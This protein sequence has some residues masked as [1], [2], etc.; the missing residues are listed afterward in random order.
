MAALAD[1]AESQKIFDKL[2]SKPANKVCFDCG[3]KAPTWASVPFGIYLCL[4]CSAVHRNL[5]VHI[6]FVRSTVLDQW[7]WDQLR[8]M[9]VG[10]NKAIQEFF[11]D[12][13]GSAALSAKD[14]KVKYQSNAATKYKEEIKRRAA[15]DA[16]IHPEFDVDDGAIVV[17]AEEEEEDFFSSWDKPAIKR[18][19]PS[20][21]RTGTPVSRTASPFLNANAAGNGTSRPKSPLASGAKA[22]TPAGTPPA[23]VVSKAVPAA[24]AAATRAKPTGAGA[25][26]AKR[27]VLSG[28]K[29]Q[30]IGAKKVVAADIDF[31]AAEKKAKEEAERIAKLGY[32]PDADEVDEKPAKS[33][34]ASPT[35]SSS[36][37][38]ANTTA[39]DTEKTTAQMARLGFGQI[40]NNKPAPAP[41]KKM[42][43]FGSTGTRPVDDDSE[44]YARDKFGT[45]KAISSDQFFGRNA[46]DPSA[47]A[48][49]KTRLQNFDG[50]TAI[51]SNAYFGREEEEDNRPTSGDFSSLEG[52]ARDIARRFAGTAG[53]DLENISQMV[54]QGVEKAQDLL[55]QYMR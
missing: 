32:D 45:Q 6:S 19:S 41:A 24:A 55:R 40:A 47:Q 42:G 11:I 34:V 2:K 12:N 5:G 1:K 43:G 18:P 28:K 36:S 54:G 37:R 48:E 46:Y 38:S 50:A 51:S 44:R 14:A 8:L 10:G 33:S 30:K 23:T 29:T 16:K 22:S 15:E 25:A 52:T 3:G 35:I 31:E 49:A 39:A 17:T 9:K 20:P 27:G 26:G 4:D 13:G 7:T 53:D 21:S